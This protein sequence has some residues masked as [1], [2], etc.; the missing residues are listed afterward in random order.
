[1]IHQVATIRQGAK[2]PLIAGFV[3]AAALFAVEAATHEA[4]A[5]S[6]RPLPEVRVSR[7]SWLVTPKV[8]FPGERLTSRPDILYATNGNPPAMSS[9]MRGPRLGPDRFWG[10]PAY[11][12]QWP[13]PA[14]FYARY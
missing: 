2:R 4:M 8:A 1:M 9:S 13:W 5:Q 14:A 3:A 11:M 7:P 12:V 10:G 6:R